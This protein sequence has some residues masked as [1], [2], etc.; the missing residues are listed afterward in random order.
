M[1]C[2]LLAFSAIHAMCTN[3]YTHCAVSNLGQMAECVFN[4][5]K[6][7]LTTIFSQHPSVASLLQGPPGWY[8]LSSTLNFS[9]LGAALPFPQLPFPIQL[10]LPGF[11]GPP[12]CCTW[13]PSLP[14]LPHSHNSESWSLWN[15]LDVSASGCAFFFSYSQLSLPTYLGPNKFLFFIHIHIHVNK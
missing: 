2:L 12:G 4:L 6:W 10:W 11:L 7:M 3:P 5:S 14:A 1:C 9:S 13:F 15:P 8:T